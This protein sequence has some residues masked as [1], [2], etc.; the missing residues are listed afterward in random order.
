MGAPSL[1]WNESASSVSLFS[2]SRKCLSKILCLWLLFWYT[3]ILHLDYSTELDF[4]RTFRYFLSVVELTSS[5]VLSGSL[6]D[7]A[8]KMIDSPVRI[9]TNRTLNINYM[10]QNIAEIRAKIL[11]C[12]IS[13][14]YYHCLKSC[15]CSARN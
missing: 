5:S 7:L 13:L 8:L 2:G 9:C 15:S 10:V 1:F 4:S 6:P 11:I 12:L 14:L 3:V